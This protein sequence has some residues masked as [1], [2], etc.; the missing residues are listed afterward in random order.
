M[1]N[2]NDRWSVNWDEKDGFFGDKTIS[3]QAFFKT[4]AE[5]DRFIDLALRKLPK[6]KY[7]TAKGY[8]PGKNE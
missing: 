4:E 5:R 1:K 6:F 2:S 7:V 8:Y 3:K